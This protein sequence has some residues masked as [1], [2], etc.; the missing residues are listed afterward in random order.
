[1]LTTPK[2]KKKLTIAVQGKTPQVTLVD[3]WLRKVFAVF[4][5][6][7]SLIAKTKQRDVKTK[8]RYNWNGDIIEKNGHRTWISI[9]SRGSPIHTKRFPNSLAT[10]EVEILTM[11]C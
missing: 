10:R 9:H 8:W 1:M 5:T 11:S 4:E 3:R 2:L 6:N 7:E